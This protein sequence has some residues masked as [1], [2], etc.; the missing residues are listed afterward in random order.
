MSQQVAYYRFPDQATWESLSVST[1]LYVIDPQ[2]NERKLAIDPRQEAIHVVGLIPADPPTDPP[3]FR[4]GWHV[5]AILL[6]PPEELDQYLV[7]CNNAYCVF[8]GWPNAIPDDGTLA[9]L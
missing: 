3:T 7:I 9:L 2:T 8:G 5:N 6:D 1:G 4:P